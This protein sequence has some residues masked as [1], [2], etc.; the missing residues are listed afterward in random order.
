[1]DDDTNLETARLLLRPWRVDAV[2]GTML[3]TAIRL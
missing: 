1:M 3:Y 2:H